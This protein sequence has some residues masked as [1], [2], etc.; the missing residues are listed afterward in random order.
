MP[1]RKPAQPTRWL[2]IG[3]IA[4]TVLFHGCTSMWGGKSEKTDEER[5]NDLINRVPTAPDLIRDAA[6]PRGMQSI[7]VEGVGVVNGLP[8]TGGPA[9]PSA[10]RDQL[11]EEMKRNDVTKPNQ[12]LELD[13]TALVRVRALIPPGARRGDPLDLMVLSPNRSRVSDLHGGWLLETRL[14]HQQVL[15]SKLRQSDVMAMAI[16]P[17]L[18]RSDHEAGKDAALK[19]EARILAGGRVQNDRNLGLILR[20]EFQHVKMSSRIANVIND[21]FFFFDGSTRRGIATAKEDDYIEIE[22][23]PRYRGNKYRLMSVI[24]AMGAK[25]HVSES[26]QRLEE[27][28]EQL[29]NPATAADASLQ[30]EAIGENAIPTLMAAMK[31]EN[32]EIRFYVAQTLAYLDQIEALDPLEDSAREVPAFRHSAL[33]ALE[34][35][36]QQLAIDTLMNLFAQPSLETRY[37]AFVAIRRR[38]DGRRKLAGEVAGQACR[39][40]QVDSPAPPAVVVSLRE[41]PEVVLFGEV[42][43]LQIDGFLLGPGGLILKQEPS[44]PNKIRVSRFQAGVDDRRVVTDNSVVSLVKAI[45]NVGGGYGDVI[46]VLRTAKDKGFLVDQ[47]ALDPLPKPLRT[48]YRDGVATSVAADEKP[49]SI[50]ADAK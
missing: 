20:P 12:F 29:S 6:V 44:N 1:G 18:T 49:K 41:S 26:Q 45:V 24:L 25:P 39:I 38:D 31:T 14:R 8:G 3:L 35:M 46:S 34:A 7:T 23:H 28:S 33:S 13:E 5:L 4:S 47:L 19:T 15:R 16:G 37:G 43:P 32:P 27:L 30:L 36:P 50:W 48:Y 21:R 10:F 17:T 9:D 11:L 40:Y 22:V 42:A 2:M